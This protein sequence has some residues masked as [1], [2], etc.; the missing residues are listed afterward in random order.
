MGARLREALVQAAHLIADAIEAEREACKSMPKKAP[1]KTRRRGR[2]QRQPTG[3]PMSELDV[4]RARQAARRA[5]I[6]IP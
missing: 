6:P 2:T 1:A 4:E 3:R 5:G